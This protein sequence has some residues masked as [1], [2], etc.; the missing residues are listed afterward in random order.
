LAVTA[1]TIALGVFLA[2][3]AF[4]LWLLLVWTGYQL[5]E[6]LRTPS[7]VASGSR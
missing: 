5:G 4:T 6:H 7:H 3:V 2:L 1:R